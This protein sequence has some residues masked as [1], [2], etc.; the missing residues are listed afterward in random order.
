M[1]QAEHGRQILAPR[2]AMCL[3]N[4][5]TDSIIGGAKPLLLLRRLGLGYTKT[6]TRR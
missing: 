3:Y 4:W 6:K 2:Q 5:F 1:S